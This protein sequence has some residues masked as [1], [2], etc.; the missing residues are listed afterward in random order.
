M[1]KEQSK[2]LAQQL[3][4]FEF[5]EA[6]YEP[7]GYCEAMGWA[8]DSK[9]TKKAVKKKGLLTPASK[10]YDKLASIIEKC[11]SINSIE[12]MEKS[13]VSGFLTNCVALHMI[14]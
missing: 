10:D 1:N 7:L 14:A 3:L 11:G 6:N 8:E 4:D 5:S 13:E 2:T 12:I 9:E